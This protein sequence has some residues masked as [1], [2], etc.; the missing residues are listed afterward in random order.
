MT[1]AT[2]DISLLEK[3]HNASAKTMAQARKEVATPTDIGG[4]PPDPN[5]K[6]KD[7]N[8]KVIPKKLHELWFR[9]QEI[10]TMLTQISHIRS[11]CVKAQDEKDPLFAELNFN[12]VA[13]T[14]G[15]LYT[16]LKSTMPYCVCPLCQGE[17]CRACEH[18]GLIGKFRYDTCTPKELKGTAAHGPKSEEEP[19]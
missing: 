4:P 18:R 15:S 6:V 13:A 12:Q 1:T 17:G 14:A 8:G 10:Q 9:K 7:E 5:A 2:L 19:R 11:A 16:E 3:V